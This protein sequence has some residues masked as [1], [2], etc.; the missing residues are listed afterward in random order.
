M[1]IEKAIRR[2]TMHKML[3]QFIRKAYEMGADPDEAAMSLLSMAAQVYGVEV[4]GAPTHSEKLSATGA[5][6]VAL[7]QTWNSMPSIHEDKAIND[8]LK[9]NG[10]GGSDTGS[11]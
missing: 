3:C 4:A 8:A 5:M 11:D 6:G 10:Y 9:R 1:G 2:E 7:C